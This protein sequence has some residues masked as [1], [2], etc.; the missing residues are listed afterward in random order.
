[1]VPGTR[2]GMICRLIRAWVLMLLLF[3]GRGG[4]VKVVMPLAVY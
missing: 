3:E 1:M 4:K 2:L